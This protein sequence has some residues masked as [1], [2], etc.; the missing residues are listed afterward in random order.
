M[1]AR[2][3]I[4]VPLGV[5]KKMKR[6]QG[7]WLTSCLTITDMCQ[8]TQMAAHLCRLCGVMVVSCERGYDAH[9]S[10]FNAR[11][12]LTRLEDLSPSVQ[13]ASQ[14]VANGWFVEGLLQKIQ[15]PGKQVPYI[16]YAIYSAWLMLRGKS[17]IAWMQQQNL[18][19]LHS[20]DTC[21]KHIALARCGTTWDVL[22]SERH[23]RA[24]GVSQL[25]HIID[26]GWPQIRVHKVIV[27]E[28]PKSKGQAH[29]SKI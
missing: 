7:R 16:T 17:R 24:K 12:K 10:T 11:Y 26:N 3:S 14:T 21:M 27:M 28:A 23:P 8:C 25:Y 29:S 22:A 1:S 2:L 19:T 15:V 6:K 20:M 4:I 5:L 13:V 18:Q 9:V